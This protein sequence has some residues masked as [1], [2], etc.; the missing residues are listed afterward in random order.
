MAILKW[1]GGVGMTVDWYLDVAIRAAGGLLV[2][3]CA[4]LLFS[5]F[6]ECADEIYDADRD[7]AVIC[8]PALAET[9]GEQTMPNVSHEAHDRPLPT[10]APRRPT[11]I[12]LP[13]NPATPPP[14]AR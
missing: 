4:Y 12:A 6:K 13:S 14:G 3:T 9:V 11:L 8:D 5:W 1:Y 10:R 2:I 7:D